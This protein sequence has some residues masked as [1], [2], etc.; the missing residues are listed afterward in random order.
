MVLV[1]DAEKAS[2]KIQQLFRMEN[3]QTRNRRE[4]QH[5]KRHIKNTQL[6]SYSTVKN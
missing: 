5:G 6:T 2:D 3:T 4:L 1:I